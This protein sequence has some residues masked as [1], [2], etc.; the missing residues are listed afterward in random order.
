MSFIVLFIYGIDNLIHSIFDKKRGGEN[1]RSETG[2]SQ[3]YDF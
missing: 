2:V 1:P 3:S